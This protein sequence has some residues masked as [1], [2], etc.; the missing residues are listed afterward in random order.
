MCLR[1]SIR[2]SFQI[3]R[4]LGSQVALDLAEARARC[5]SEGGDGNLEGERGLRDETH[6]AGL[7]GL[8]DGFRVAI[9]GDKHHRRLT[10][11]GGFVDLPAGGET[12]YSGH[13]HIEE[14]QIERL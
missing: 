12:V 7:N 1:S 10:I 6:R 5:E 4:L 9:A 13:H 14:N 2:M 3:E 11:R 8:S